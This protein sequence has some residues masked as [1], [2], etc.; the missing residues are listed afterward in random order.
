VGERKGEEEVMSP[1][2]QITP[3]RLEEKEPGNS[4]NNTKKALLFGDVDDGSSAGRTIVVEKW[5]M[6]PSGVVVEAPALHGQ[7]MNSALLV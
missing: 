6:V 2:K 4:P 3:V 1:T 5:L 7:H